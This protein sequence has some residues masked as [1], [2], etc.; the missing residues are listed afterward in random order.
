MRRKMVT[1]ATAVA[2]TFSLLLPVYA[3]STFK[4]EVRV[5]AAAIATNLEISGESVLYSSGTCFFVG[6]IKT[7]PQYL[8]TNH[9]VIADFLQLGAGEAVGYKAD[10]GNVYSLRATIRVY[11]DANDYEEAYVVDYNETKDIAVL[12]LASPTAKRQAIAFEVPTDDMV[13]ATV[14][15]VGYPGIADN[16]VTAPVSQ[17]GVED[18]TVTT[19][20]VSRL[21]TSSG[22]GVRQIQT[23][24]VIQHGNSGGPLVNTNG[25]VI[26]INTSS[27]SN[28]VTDERVRY[29]VNIEEMMDMLD[30][31]SIKYTVIIPGSDIPVPAIA[32]VAAVAVVVLAVIFFMKTKKPAGPV[33]RDDPPQ[34]IHI[35][36]TPAVRSMAEQHRGA[37]FELNGRQILIGRD[38]AVCQIVFQGGTPGVSARHCSLGWEESTGD[39][40]L[41]DLR[42]TYGTWL[43]NG[44]RITPGVVYRLRAGD[45]FYLGENTNLLRVELE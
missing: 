12:R 30:K 43:S 36:R 1:L 7:D 8:V 25:H 3:S 28:S 20:T 9:H 21:I 19:G 4:K 44:Q 35:S 38:S 40:L 22:T 31:N 14:Y 11:Y 33:K 23:D 24:T 26:G 29:A 34:P 18:A 39:F 10:D 13:G 6:N 42:S 15:A 27:V 45:S 5:S 2:L 17:W 37:R 41:T 32:A 16:S